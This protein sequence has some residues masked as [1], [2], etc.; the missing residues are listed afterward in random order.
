GPGSAK[1]QAWLNS[2][3]GAF[4]KKFTEGLKEAG[5]KNFDSKTNPMYGYRPFVE[6]M[7]RADVPFDD[8]FLNQLGHD[9]IAAE[10]DN[11]T[12]FEQWGG[13]HRE[14]RADALDSLLGVMS[15]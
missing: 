6:M 12:I 10:K 3:D 9:M 7:T 11:G 5:A 14:G 4:Y 15:K 1:Y 2:P 8:Q 13:N